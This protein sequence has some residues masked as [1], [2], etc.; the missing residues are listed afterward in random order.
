MKILVSRTDKAGDLI[1][2]TPI[3]RELRKAFPKAN[4]V[5]HI[6][7]Y[8][9]PILEFCHEIDEVI[10]DDPCGQPMPTLQLAQLLKSKAFTHAV[11]VHPKS[12]VIIA[13]WLAKIPY[14][15]G[16]ASN[17]WQFFLSERKVQKRS[18]NLQHEFKYNL[19]LIDNICANICYDG[20]H[21]KVQTELQTECKKY[22]ENAGM[23]NSTPVIIHPG[24]GGSAHNL[25]PEQY[26][27][28]YQSLSKEYP[29]LISLGPG[30]EAIRK[31][32]PEPIE[33]KLGFLTNV[34]DLH[35]LASVFSLCQ[36]FIG[37]S[38][39]PMHLAAAVGLPVAAFFPPQPSMTPVRWG[40]V[41]ENAKVFIPK[42]DKCIS[43]CHNCSLSPCMKDI[44]LSEAIN[45]LKSKI[46]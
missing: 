41:G 29:V 12:R 35:Q 33:N 42:V 8:T 6:R 5:A 40:P 37:G 10:I 34:P 9:A 32:F 46:S 21:F 43:K 39:G 44:K 19:D 30:E 38:T 2:T 18:R 23:A 20:P 45:W 36:G 7:S 28:L 13:S 31:F 14:R 15:V 1:L 16:R 11:I 26:V 22:L 3:F 25:S 4:I 17:I 27:E 24:H